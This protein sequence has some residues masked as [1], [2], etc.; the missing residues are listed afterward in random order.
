MGGLTMPQLALSAV[1]GGGGGTDILKPSGATASGNLVVS[2]EEC[3]RA[4]E[5][6]LG[7]PPPR[8][9]NCPQS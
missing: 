5:A 2:P 6:L 9:P 7:E 8:E 1:L 3:K 4:A